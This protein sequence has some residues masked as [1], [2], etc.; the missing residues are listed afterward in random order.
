[1]SIEKT[2]PK[3]EI[4]LL[5]SPPIIDTQPGVLPEQIDALEKAY[6]LPFAPAQEEQKV[7]KKFDEVRAYYDWLK[8]E[9]ARARAEEMAKYPPER[10]DVIPAQRAL[11]L[12]RPWLERIFES[13]RGESNAP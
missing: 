5:V 12:E 7:Q 10:G 1:M 11:I 9:R 3:Q 6:L 8:A 2:T 4:E 13:M